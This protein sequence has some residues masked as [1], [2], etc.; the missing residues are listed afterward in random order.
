M[1]SLVTGM[2]LAAAGALIAPLQAQQHPAPQGAHAAPGG[3]A[4]GAMAP[5]MA[6]HMHMMDSLGA[7]MDTAIALMNRATGEARTPAMQEVLR[8][9]VAAHKA[10]LLHMREM[11]SHHPMAD[12][13]ASPRNAAPAPDA[14][15]SASRL[16]ESTTEVTG[17]DPVAR[18]YSRPASTARVGSRTQSRKLPSYILAS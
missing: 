17:A 8:E 4:A 15:R 12:S 1:K 5:A 18:D 9:L 2:M 16:D 10:M 3:H 7:R 6:T 14:R 13:A 11:A